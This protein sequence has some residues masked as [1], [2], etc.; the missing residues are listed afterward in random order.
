MI[1]ICC[2]KCGSINIK[3]NGHTKSRAQKYHCKAC[4]FYGTL[5]TQEEKQKEKDRLIE[6]LLNERS[7]Q[8]EIARVVGVSRNR[9]ILFIKKK[10]SHLLQQTS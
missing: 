2:R 5:I 1:N 3:K 10:P 7:S 8:R 9:I 6:K 4:N